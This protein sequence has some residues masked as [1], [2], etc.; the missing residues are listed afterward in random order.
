MG[1]N[2]LFQRVNRSSREKEPLRKNR[3]QNLKNRKN[4]QSPK[5]Q[6]I[7]CDVEAPSN[8]CPI[9]QNQHR[10]P[11]NEKR[12]SQRHKVYYRLYR[13]EEETPQ[14]KT[15]SMLLSRNIVR[16]RTE[17]DVSS[18]KKQQP[19]KYLQKGNR[20]VRRFFIRGLERE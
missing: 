7:D 16:G 11:E 17:D 20:R 19:V 10:C 2:P 3:C 18:K 8:P 12:N 5:Y 9:Y 6:S 15:S 1:S 13:E 4:R 14:R